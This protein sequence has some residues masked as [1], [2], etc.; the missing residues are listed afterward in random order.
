[1]KYPNKNFWQELLSY[2]FF[3][4]GGFAMAAALSMALLSFAPDGLDTVY[5]HI[6]QWGQ[7]IFLMILP[8]LL[9][10]HFYLKTSVAEELRLKCPDVRILLL[11]TGLIVAGIPL[12]EWLTWIGQHLP[13][14][15][16]LESWAQQQQ[17]SSEK[18]LHALL[19]VDGPW[20]WIALFLLICLATAVGEELMFRGALLNIFLRTDTPRWLIALWI[21]F[22]FSLIHFDIYG[23]LPRWALGSLFVYLVYWSGSI[24][25]GILAHTLN[26]LIALLQYKLISDTQEAWLPAPGWIIGSAVIGCLFLYLLRKR[27]LQ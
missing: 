13:L 8:P 19:D 4:L 23:L 6:I 17:I 24:W 27:S 10:S 16:T 9:W 15:Q 26:N 5:L 2:L 25:P 1:M 20:G 22:I 7:T 12:L 18:I 3:C 11:T 14:P 21:G